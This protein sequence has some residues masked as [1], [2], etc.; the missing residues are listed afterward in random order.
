MQREMGSSWLKG[1]ETAA[2]TKKEG[3][4][5]GDRWCSWHGGARL[6]VSG[7]VSYKMSNLLEREKVGLLI[8]LEGFVNCNS[9]TYF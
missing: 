3:G 8:S 5:D 9:L 1:P 2:A 7:L 4:V 6:P